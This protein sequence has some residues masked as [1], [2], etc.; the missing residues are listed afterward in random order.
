MAASAS[1]R[2]VRQADVRLHPTQGVTD[3]GLGGCACPASRCASEAHLAADR[4]HLT[5][6]EAGR[7]AAT[8]GARR[9]VLTHFSQRYDDPAAFGVEA[10]RYHDD[11]VVGED[12]RRVAMPERAT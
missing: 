12:L 8:A 2:V 10:P 3:T 1:A 6:Q 11:T 4:G 7:V 5:A 9:L